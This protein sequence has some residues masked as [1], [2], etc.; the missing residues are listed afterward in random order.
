MP[1]LHVPAIRSD[2]MRPGIRGDAELVLRSVFPAVEERG[3]VKTTDE[4][5]LLG[6]ARLGDVQVL[7]LDIAMP[8]ALGHSLEF[9]ERM[10]RA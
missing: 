4:E 9:R 1:V 10:L 3:E 6:Q 8:P 5:V 7:V 2:R